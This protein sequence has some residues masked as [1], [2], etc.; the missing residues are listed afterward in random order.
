MSNRISQLAAAPS[1]TGAELVVV[2]KLSA[3]VTLTATT[4][5][6]QASD[7]S[8]NDSANGFVAAGFAV[9]K[10]VKVSGF[11]GSA[12]NNIFSAVVTAVAPGKLTIAGTDGDVIVDDAA[13][14]SVTITQWDSVRTTGQDVADLGKAYTD[15][16]VAGL[17]WKQAVR[18]ATVAAGTLASG[19]ENGDTIDGV[20]LATGDRILIKDQASGAEN[21]IYVVAASGAP[22]RATDAD[23]GAEL[24]NASVYVSEGTTNSDTQWTCTTNAPITPGTTSL[25]FAQLTSGSGIT[26]LTGD[27]TAS[28]SG[29]AAATIANDA[30]S[31][32]KL[33]NMANSTIKGRTTAGSGDPEDMTAA[34]AAAI[35][36]GDGLTADLCGFR[37]IPQNSQSVNYTLVA[38]DAGK[39]ILHPSGGGSGDT[40]TIPSN[41]SVAFPIGTSVTFINAD[42][43][44]ISIAIT[45]DTLTLANSITTGTRTLAQ[46]GV[47]TAVKTTST[48][49]IISGAGLS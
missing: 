42:S 30:V 48:G 25:A 18:A 29:S 6:A 23:S 10:A 15:A 5:S 28:G 21:G 12:A 2:S 33:A 9:G 44:S 41:A 7:N 37:G 35:V 26:A 11:T 31:N 32:A 14:E 34:Q 3:T 17:S 47:A 45:S 8:F 39:H 13:G 36:Q 4:L 38:A 49:W 22:T 1:L 24:V 40:I 16:K 19:F 46:N 43:N 27:V 20:M